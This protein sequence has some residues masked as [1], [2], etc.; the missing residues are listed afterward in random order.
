ML[1]MPLTRHLYAEDEVVAA[2]QFCVLR[3]RPVEAAFWCEELLYSEMIDP[4]LE[5]LRRIWLYGFGIGALNWYRA[6]ERLAAQAELN[7]DELVGLVVGLCR[8]GTA[9]R[10]D[11][12]YLIL[13][14]S[15]EP[16]EQAAF[17]IGPK[18]FTGADAYFIACI[19]QGR[20][21]SA[22]RALGSVTG[23]ALRVAAERKHG[24][25]GLDACDLLVEYPALTV[26]ALCL[27]KGELSQRLAEPVLGTLREVES[28]RAE[29]E[30]LLG[31]KARRQYPI[32]SESLYWLTHRGS[33]STY[34]TSEKVL[35][36]SL[37]RPGKL[38]GSVY[39]DSIAEGL[40]GWHAIR[41]DPEV[42]MAFYDEHFPDD[43]PDEWSTAERE[44]SHGR[45]ASQPGAA[46]S[47]EKFLNSWFRSLPSAVIWNGF[48]SAAKGLAQIKNWGDITPVPAH[49]D[50]NLVR[51]TRRIVV[52]G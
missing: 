11:I 15:S 39:W 38:W 29:W 30:P 34:D 44:K 45:G 12:S 27:P 1:H 21:I 10:R 23:P 46:P 48:A 5:G 37:E 51:L 6:F 3:G 8:A 4:L 42:R 50:L 41:N 13:A 14:G 47:A 43:I 7:V 31:R 35:C 17:C 40:G 52:V 28:A 26:A 20:T 9:G 19:Q 2:L 49:H 33:R 24:A 32:P 18:G 22:W 25:A 16:A 36:G